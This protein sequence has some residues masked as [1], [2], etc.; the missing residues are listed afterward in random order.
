MKVI[1]E[2][3]RLQ[4]EDLEKEEKAFKKI[5]AKRRKNI[6]RSF[7]NLAEIFGDLESLSAG[8][9]K[10]LEDFDLKITE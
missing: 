5:W 2:A 4:Q 1:A 6:E 9:V 7:E 3:H 10:S 8:N